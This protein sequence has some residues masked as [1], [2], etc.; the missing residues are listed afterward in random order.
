LLWFVCSLEIGS[1]YIAQTDME[2][3]HPIAS[4][5]RVLGKYTGIAVPNCSFCLLRNQFQISLT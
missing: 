3:L 2:N 4:A 5:S 1:S